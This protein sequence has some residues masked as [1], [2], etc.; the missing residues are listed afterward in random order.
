MNLDKVIKIKVC[1]RNIDNYIKRMIKRNISFIEIIPVSK[2][3]VY[4]ILRVNDYL[5]LI[6]YKSV[7]YEV[8]I[9]E[10]KGILKLKDKFNTNKILLLFLVFGFVLIY[11]LSNMIFSVDVI[12]HD[13]NIRDLI[14][15]E[16]EKYDIVKY[17][18]KKSYLELEKI[19]DKILESN[20]DVLEWLEIN[21]NGTFV[22]VRVEE[23]ILNDEEMEYQYQD[24]V[25]KKDAVITSV[26]A[27]SGVIL[28]EKGMY[29]KEG[30]VVISGSVVHPN[31]S[32]VLG[33][34]VGE[35]CGEV[36]YEV[37]IDYP[38]VYQ[39]S[40][41]TGRSKT[42]IVLNFFDKKINLFGKGNYKSFA[43]KNKVLF[44]DNFLKLEVIKEKRYEMD[45]K[46]EVYTEELVENKAI[47]YIKD[48]LMK[49]NPDIREVSK[50]EVMSRDVDY[51]G[52]RF[53][54]FV[55]TVEDIGMVKRVEQDKEET[56]E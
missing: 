48:K 14:Y 5:E 15:N 47:N 42:G 55:T 9:V 17:S 35:V 34:A 36:W 26:R 29:V 7:L 23:R 8:S 18:F 6:K 31:N 53:K 45:I 25:S 27:S 12:H 13:K 41:L 4:I 37:D 28:K 20:K 32:S 50:L 19:E 46:D 43:S 1:G 2:N 10:K 22:T 49:D 51:D 16:L 24:I 38:F 33:M 30:E 44:R 56:L 11:G 52:I 21:I 54:F 3:E 39:E 40:N